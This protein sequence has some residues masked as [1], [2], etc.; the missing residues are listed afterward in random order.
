MPPI[1]HPKPGRAGLAEWSNV[2]ASASAVGRFRVRILEPQSGP[3]RGERTWAR[4]RKSTAADAHRLPQQAAVLTYELI[5]EESGSELKN[6]D[7]GK[8]EA[9]CLL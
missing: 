7:F 1:V 3:N 2:V 6:V 9:V 5:P 4:S 8:T